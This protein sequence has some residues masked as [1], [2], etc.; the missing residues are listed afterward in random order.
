MKICILRN[1]DPDSGNKWLVACQKQGIPADVIDLCAI[2]ALEK[3]KAGNY[4]LCLLRPPGTHEVYKSIYDERLYHVVNSLNIPCFPSFFECFIYEN[5][6]SL[7]AFLE[8]SDIKHPKTWI[9]SHYSE[10]KAFISSTAYPIVVKTSIGATGSGVSVI[11]EPSQAAKYIHQAFKGKGIRKRV[12]PNKQVGTPKSWL[13]KALSD[14][15]YLKMKLKKYFRTYGDTQKNF[16]IFQEYIEHDFEWRLVKIGESY[17]AYKKFKV[18]DK[19]SGAKNLGYGNPPLDLMNWI[20]DIANK[21]HIHT[22]A[23]DVLVGKNGYYMNEIQTIFG[24]VRDHILEVDGKPGRYLY[25]D[26]KWVFEEGMFNS[27]ESYDLRLETALELFEQG[28]L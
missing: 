11:R 21:Y 8:L 27:N 14:P 5:K 3:I 23:F 17:F 20:Y 18:G 9:I 26:N 6:K 16:V 19:A 24:H 2:D 28:R 4:K 15:E 12:G 7:A 13:K 22:A 1:E 10:V 25:Q